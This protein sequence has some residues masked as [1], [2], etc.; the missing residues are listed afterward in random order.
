MFSDLNTILKLLTSLFLEK[1][2][3]FI[4][5]DPVKLSSAILGLKSMMNPFSWCHS[6]IPIL[7]GQLLDYIESPCPKLCGITKDS[8]DILINDYYLE[9]E[10]VDSFT[11]VY[12]DHF[13]RTSTDFQAVNNSF[14]DSPELNE[15]GIAWCS[16]EDAISYE[17]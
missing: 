13:Q 15:M 9:R 4:S 14:E 3:I 17:E 6:L 10:F 7:P 1:S 8:Y 11:W 12:L 16:G 5:Q 2:V